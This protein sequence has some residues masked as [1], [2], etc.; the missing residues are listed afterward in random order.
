MQDRTS[1][2]TPLESLMLE[3]SEHLAC[4]KRIRRQLP[5]WGRI[6]I[7][8]PLPFLCLYRKPVD[9]SDNGTERLVTGE[10]S[11]ML[12]SGKRT[13]GTS[14][15]NLVRS[16]A[17]DLR[18]RFGSFLLL[19]IWASTSRVED[20]PRQPAFR[21]VTPPSYGLISTV[22]RLENSLK[23]IS[24]AGQKAK[25]Q[26]AHQT[27]IAPPGMPPLISFKEAHSLGIHVIGIETRPLYRDEQSGQT[28]PLV[29]RRLHKQIA[30]TFKQGLY[31][32]T[33]SQTAHF[34]LH[35]LA[36]GRRVIQKTVS[37]VDRQLAEVSR[38]FDFLLLV[39]PVNTEAAWRAFRKGYFEKSPEFFYRPL[40]IEPS[41]LKRA[42]FKIPVERIED[43]VLAQ[44]FREKQEELDLQISLLAVR[45]TKRFLYG[46]LQLYGGVT[47]EEMLLARDILNRLP[48]RSRDE[49]GRGYLDAPSFCKRAEAEIE[50][51]REAHGDATASVQMRD[52]YAG[53]LVSKDTI[54]VGRHSRIPVPRVDALLQH[55]VGTHLVTYINGLAQP[56]QLLQSGLAG[57][58][59][60][61][62][63]LAVLAEYLAG[64]LSRPR[65]RLL[66]ARIIAVRRLVEGVSFVDTFRELDRSLDF[67]QRLAFT[68][69]MRV[70]RGGGLT[71]DAIYLRGF[72]QLLDYLR[73]G[74]EI[75]PLFMGKFDL[76]HVPIVR[77]LEWRHVLKPP[78]LVPRYMTY[79]RTLERLNEIRHTPTPLNLFIRRRMP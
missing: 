75:E 67:S 13:L 20:D 53:V 76:K 24:V 60:L 5:E 22:N 17:R 31:E 10:A 25:V 56:L 28:F 68:T 47:E 79:P 38:L 14:L 63:G 49:A 6:H 65:L 30:T 8:R 9:H 46:N 61:Q 78:P 19:E 62:E 3:V 39:S 34:P 21:I 48:P 33:S 51:Y 23:R 26:V 2:K 18:E 50:Y 11:Y 55:E 27:R 44:L 58:E 1:G 66:A 73:R 54:L 43:P 16:L 32:F 52:D 42:L 74:G 15:A 35:Y 12:C 57:Y 59:L 4:E 70:Y 71:K 41:L 36:L 64:G 77:E 37:E 7:D 72:M 45:G 69:T 29:L 40:P